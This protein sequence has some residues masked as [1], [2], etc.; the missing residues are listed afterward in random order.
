M[1]IDPPGSDPEKAPPDMSPPS[2][3]DSAQ[4]EILTAEEQMRRF[5]DDLKNTDWG[6]QPC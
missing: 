5:E 2:A 6:H 1:L 3:T 4:P